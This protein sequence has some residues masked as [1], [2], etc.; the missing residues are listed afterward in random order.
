MYNGENEL[1]ECLIVERR[2]INKVIVS[3][4]VIQNGCSSINQYTVSY[5]QTLTHHYCF[6]FPYIS[7]SIILE[8]QFSFSF[9]FLP[10][11]IYHFSRGEQAVEQSCSK[12]N[13]RLTWTEALT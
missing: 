9:V 7:L 3:V 13:K 6:N 1:S 2:L 4:D 10:F 12:L 5:L 11:C 8:I